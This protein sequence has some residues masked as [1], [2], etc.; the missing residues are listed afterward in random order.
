MTVSTTTA[1]NV[2]TGN[3]VTTS[4][5]FDFAF[6]VAG[7]LVVNRVVITSGVETLQVLTT[8]YTV[9]GGSGATGTI[10]M[11]SAPPDTDNLVIERALAYTQGTDYQPNDPFPAEVNE[12]ALDRLTFL[13][14]QVLELTKRA[15]KL[16][17][18]TLL[19]GIEFPIPVALKLFRWNATATALEQTD[20]PAVS[21]A[22]A[23]VSETN[24]ATS[25]TNAATSET[26]A[27]VSEA[28]AASNARAE[29]YDFDAATAM[30]APGT[31]NIRY[32]NASVS[33]VT[34]I[35]I[36]ANTAVAGAPDIS[37]HIDT[38]DDSN[39]LALRGTITIRKGGAPATFAIFSVNG[40]ITDNGSWL[41][42][43]VAHVA[44]GGA[45]SAGDDMFVEFARTGDNG[46]L[47]SL[48]EDTTP[49][50][51][52][53][54]DV[55]SKKIVSVSN[56]NILIDVNGTGQLRTSVDGVEAMRIDQTGVITQPLQC[57][58]LALNTA[59]NLNVTGNVLTATIEFDDDSTNGY[60]QNNDFN[61]TTDTFTAPTTGRY[62]LTA[63]IFL[64]NF[65]G[66]G[67]SI[68]DLVTS[69]R[70]YREFHSDLVDGDHTLSIY[71]ECDMDVSDTCTVT[72]AVVGMAGDTV[73]VFGGATGDINTSFSGHLIA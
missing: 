21:A 30:A 28:N 26:N 68:I 20:D 70:F 64:Q 6:E 8:D 1:R 44:S 34:Q 12:T 2:K 38:W 71:A 39:H 22:A 67:N 49:Q 35:A 5:P 4:F 47:A 13:V 43:P 54:L 50:L 65:V 59:S 63:T 19:L 3:G 14:Q 27:A 66:A 10:E 61:T 9:T 16:P 23:L 17:L 57:A 33:S 7:D 51:G 53:D 56:G 25:E 48:L 42:V 40:A 73:D 24:A 18:N 62:A 11:V 37:A 52:G 58:F 41:Q 55:N 72:V 36:A 29:K 15:V 46:L 60:D 45:W 31:G 32:N 69:N